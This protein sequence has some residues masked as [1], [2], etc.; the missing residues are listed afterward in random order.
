LPPANCPLPTANCIF[1]FRFP[2]PSYFESNS[3]FL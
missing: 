1:I 3:L 2:I